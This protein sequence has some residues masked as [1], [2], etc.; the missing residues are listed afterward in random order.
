MKNNIVG[1]RFG[2]LT[3]IERTKDKR[4]VTAYV[5]LCDCGNL[6]TVRSDR[7]I[8]EVTKSCGCLMLMN[9]LKPG[10]AA[11]NSLQSNYKISAEQRGYIWELTKEE[12]TYLMS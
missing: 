5:C 1:Q 10:E 2:L 8:H 12:A 3:T 6:T 11:L 9:R 7:L 4:G